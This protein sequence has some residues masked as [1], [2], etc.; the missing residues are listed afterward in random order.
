MR[1][2][3]LLLMLCLCGLS[4]AT[5]P[6][7]MAL[8]N[9]SFKV[10]RSTVWSTATLFDGTMIE[11]DASLSQLHLTG[12]P[13]L[14][15]G[16]ASRATIY[17]RRLVLDYGQLESAAN[18]EVEA[19]SL[20]IVAAGPD[21]LARVQ[22]RSQ[23]NV[24]VA[25]VR[26]AVRVTSAGGVLVANIEAGKTL[27]LEPQ[28]GGNA[29]PAQVSGCLL[30]KGGKMFV[31]DQTAN[32]LLEVDGTGLDR[33]LGNRVAINGVPENKAPAVAGASQVVR[34]VGLRRVAAGGCAELAKKLGAVAAAGA[35]AGASTA[36]GSGA[37]AAS[38]PAAA[39]ASAGGIGAGTVAV[40][41]GVA[42]AATMGSLGLAG[43]L[44]GQSN[45]PTV[46]R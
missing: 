38:V 28:A 10:D 22:V 37:A 44:P 19:N 9:G 4:A 46:S 3:L 18:Y 41:G 14:R 43:D 15:L 27:N 5:R 45:S 30:A 23:K 32:V 17:Q 26:G 35:A 8:T 12:G 2:T 13:D 7:G 36:A 39:A 25:A 6:I 11:T 33:E 29:A 24:Q 20:R 1:R 40:I 42:A 34:V 16:S 21:G 31:A